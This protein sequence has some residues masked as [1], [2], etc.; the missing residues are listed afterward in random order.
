MNKDIIEVY[1]EKIIRILDNRLEYNDD[2][3]LHHLNCVIEWLYC[4]WQCGSLDLEVLGSLKTIA[5][6]VYERK[7][8]EL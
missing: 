2:D 1:K 7:I 8:R 3:K 5:S 6:E 4:E